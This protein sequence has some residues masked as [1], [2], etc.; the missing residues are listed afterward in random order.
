MPISPENKKRYPANWKEIRARI[1]DRA[2]HQCEGTDCNLPNYSYVIRS[3]V[4]FCE[5]RPQDAKNQEIVAWMKAVDPKFRRVKVILTIAHMDHIP[6]NCG[7]D[8]LKSLCQSCHNEYDKHHRAK[9]R[10]ETLRKK[11]AMKYAI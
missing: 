6:E 7:D 8:N 11:K 1:L 5:D 10:A 9:N 3:G 2:N 4:G